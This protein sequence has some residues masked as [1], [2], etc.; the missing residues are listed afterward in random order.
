MLPNICPGFVLAFFVSWRT[1]HSLQVM[2]QVPHSF[3]IFLLSCE[4][5]KFLQQS[6]LFL[7]KKKLGEHWFHFVL[8]K[9]SHHCPRYF[10]LLSKLLKLQQFISLKTNLW[11]TKLLEVWSH[12]IKP[13]VKCHEQTW[14]YRRCLGLGLT[15]QG[16]SHQSV[17]WFHSQCDMHICINLNTFQ[18]E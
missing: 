8:N 2:T 15:V 11:S 4:Q 12:S 5:S 10:L 16:N 14:H 13:K 7:I 6:F 1:A 17:G 3:N 9:A 18:L